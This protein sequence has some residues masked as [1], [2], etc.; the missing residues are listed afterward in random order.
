MHFARHRPDSIWQTG[1][2]YYGNKY[3]FVYLEDCSRDLPAIEVCPEATTENLLNL[4]D[5]ALGHKGTPN[6]ALSDQ[7][8]LATNFLT[9]R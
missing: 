3:L 2:N 9:L 8:M 7:G 5:H 1:I 6:E 4:T